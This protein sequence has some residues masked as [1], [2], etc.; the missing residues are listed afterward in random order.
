MS[1]VYYGKRPTKLSCIVSICH[2]EHF[3]STQN[4][5]DIN[6]SLFPIHPEPLLFVI[7]SPGW[8]IFHWIW[9]THSCY[10]VF[11]VHIS[12]YSSQKIVPGAG[13]LDKATCVYCVY[14]HVPCHYDEAGCLHC[15][16]SRLCLFF[17]PW[18]LATTALYHCLLSF[19]FSR[20]SSGM[21]RIAYKLSNCLLSLT[22]CL[23]ISCVLSWYNGIFTF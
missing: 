13:D 18:P 23:E 10:P 3:I 9:L 22:T 11:I 4:W 1:C 8:Y 5:L 7:N 16:D 21:N 12:R 17:P 20:V 14:W 19:I 2:L 6:I 15:T